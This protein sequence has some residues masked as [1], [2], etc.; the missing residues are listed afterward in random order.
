MADKL[1]VW[2]QALT[3]LGKDNSAFTLASAVEA[4]YALE[5]AWAGVVEEAFNEGDWNFAKVSAALVISNTET[6]AI[7]WNFVFEYPD[8]YLRTIAVSNTADFRQAFYD[9]IDQG[10]FLHANQNVM[11]LRFISGERMADDKVS[12]WPTMFWRYVAMKL[13]YETCEKLTSG[14]TKQEDLERRKLKAL[15][16][17]KSVDARNENNKL[18][19]PG[20]W[21]RA[22]RGGYGG[23]GNRLGNTL[24]GGEIVLGDGDV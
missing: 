16:Q 5:A 2:K 11:Y 23:Y 21:L 17:A 7:G 1:Q 24:V 4:R 15:R 3:H 13:A 19:E 6:A 10:G 14:A 8:D 9:Y 20:S 12:T 22:R 18:E